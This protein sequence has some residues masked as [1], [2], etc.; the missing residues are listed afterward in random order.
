LQPY[1]QP[2]SICPVRSS[3]VGTRKL[4]PGRELW[5]FP[6]VPRSITCSRADGGID[7]DQPG[8]GKT[9]TAIAFCNEVEASA[10]S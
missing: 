1:R 10:C 2:K 9:P 5:E 6:A 4:P 8:L 3:G 7:G